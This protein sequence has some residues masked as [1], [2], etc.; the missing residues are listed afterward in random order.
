M[1]EVIVI[2]LTILTQKGLRQV[3]KIHLYLISK[4]IQEDTDDEIYLNYHNQ[5]EQREKDHIKSLFKKNKKHYT[6]RNQKE[7]LNAADHL[8]EKKNIFKAHSDDL[9]TR[10]SIFCINLQSSL[11]SNQDEDIN[12]H[13]STL[14][15]QK[16]SAPIT[17]ILNERKNTEV[18]GF[19]L[20]A[21]KEE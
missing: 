5:Y 8:W 12:N 11:S 17:A 4:K 13:S 2:I 10:S 19:F 16:S 15:R 14:F 21:S 9:Q 20:S 18:D 6:P 7:E 1:C 3:I